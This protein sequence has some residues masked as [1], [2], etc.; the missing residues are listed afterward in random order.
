MY[1]YFQHHWHLKTLKF[2]SIGS[3]K[4]TQQ[5]ENVKKPEY[6]VMIE[7]CDVLFV[8][9]LENLRFGELCG[10]KASSIWRIS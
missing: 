1:R 2:A 10:V 6:D 7:I 9:S 3:P 8:F 4:L 5:Q